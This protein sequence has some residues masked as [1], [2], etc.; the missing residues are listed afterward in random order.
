M[1]ALMRKARQL[2]YAR[3]AKTKKRL[4]R[5]Q[6]GPSEP[7]AV[8]QLLIDRVDDCSGEGSWSGTGT[9]EE[10]SW[11]GAGTGEEGLSTGTGE[12]GLE[13]EE[14]EE[15]EEEMGFNKNA[16]QELL[17]QA[18]DQ[19]TPSLR[20]RRGP[21]PSARTQQREKKKHQELR[22]AAIDCRPLDAGWLKGSQT[23]L[24][25]KQEPTPEE[26]QT[27]P[28]SKQEPMPE[29][30]QTP[31]AL[32]QEPMPEESQ[33]L[34][35]ASKQEPTPEETAL[36]DLKKKLRSKRNG[37]TGHN[38]TRHQAVLYFLC[39]QSKTN[40][41]ETRESMSVIVAR[42]FGKGITLLG[43]LS[44]GR[45]SGE[46]IDRLRRGRMPKSKW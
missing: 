12:K 44:A 38:F 10:G 2:R 13:N 27:P 17:V 32:K 36:R 39:Y 5:L 3:E 34:L 16:F 18:R 40:G 45:D 7:L 26:S 9:G 1:A 29:E 23:P 25:S 8:P 37:L 20:Y 33:P 46:K 31:P 6:A 22:L 4:L 15:N 42:C 30:S 28:A 19:G 41:K 21:H 11:L 14:N 35:P 43:R 24:A